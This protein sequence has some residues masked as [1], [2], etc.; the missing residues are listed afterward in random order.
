MFVL[1]LSCKMIVFIYKRLFNGGVSYRSVHLTR[2]I[3]HLAR[4][5]A[6]CNLLLDLSRGAL[7]LLEVLDQL[8]VLQDVALGV[9][10]AVQQVVL[11]LRQLHLVVV[12]IADQLRALLLQIGALN[13][14][15]ERE[16]LVLQALLCHG[17][18]HHR[19]L[20]L[21]LGDVQRVRELRLQVQLEL[22]VVVDLLIAEL[23]DQGAALLDRGAREHRLKDGV[24][25]LAHVLDDNRLA[26]LNAL[27]NLVEVLRSRQLHDAQAVCLLALRD[28]VDALQLRVGHERPPRTVAYDSSV[29]DRYDV[30]GELLV[31]PL[32]NLGLIRQHVDRRDALRHR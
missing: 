12:L 31:R 20:R 5:L 16:Q 15:D 19:A 4:L 9:G 32:C 7:G 25:R 11:E 14:D 24:D 26:F 28:P 13:L 18:V 2:R 3:D 8:D 22:R 27:L 23:H 29:L 10:Q 17:E 30:A 1:S 6:L 21:H